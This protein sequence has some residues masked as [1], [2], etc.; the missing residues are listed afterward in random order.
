MTAS[1]WHVL[2]GY[3]LNSV[4]MGGNQKFQLYLLYYQTKATALK[5]H[6]IKPTSKSG[7][8]NSKDF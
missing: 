8:K 2:T 6:R 5:Y 3:N 4:I 1:P 7:I